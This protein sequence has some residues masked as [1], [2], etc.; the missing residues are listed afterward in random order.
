[1]PSTSNPA[2]PYPAL[3]DAPSG[4]AQMQ[5]IAVAVNALLADTG[6]VNLTLAA[7]S[8][9]CRYRQIGP[10]VMI[11]IS[12]TG[13]SVASGSTAVAIVASGGLPAAARPT[14][15]VYLAANF[16]GSVVGLGA[17][18]TN[19]SISALNNS[20]STVTTVRISGSYLAG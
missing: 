9:T 17:I 6:W 2:I 3:T 8:G 11:D 18:G 12:A 7:G 4:P 5:A 10:T 20:G 15:G 16:G 1:M 13:Q 14:D 19:G